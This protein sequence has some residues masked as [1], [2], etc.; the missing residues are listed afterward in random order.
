[1]DQWAEVL[2]SVRSEVWIR[3]A[4]F[5]MTNYVVRGV[6]VL[7]PVQRG[8]T[9]P[10]HGR[11]CCVRNVDFSWVLFDVLEGLGNESGKLRL[12]LLEGYVIVFD[13][14][15]VAEAAGLTSGGLEDD[16]GERDVP[17]ANTPPALCPETTGVVG[18]GIV[19]GVS[20]SRDIHDAVV[21]G[22]AEEAKC[23]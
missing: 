10:Y 19:V 5:R 4:V 23:S 6:G 7:G 16:G 18:E 1:M 2:Q 13:H 11:H 15:L 14:A 12:I 17:G 22:V 21:V 3:K 8:H 20:I 9:R